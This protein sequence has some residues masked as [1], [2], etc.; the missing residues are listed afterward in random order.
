MLGKLEWAARLGALAVAFSLTAISGAAAIYGGQDA[1]P[2]AFPFM[3]SLEMELPHGIA[4]CGGT[5]ISDQWVLT[6]AHC[7]IDEGA[8]RVFVYAGSDNQ[9]QG[10]KIQADQWK[11]HPNYDVTYHNNDLALIHLPRPPQLTP[12]FKVKWS[13]NPNRFPDPVALSDTF[14]ASFHRDVTVV[15]WG[16]TAPTRPIAGTIA[17]GGAGA[18][19]IIAGTAPTL[20]ML[21]FRVASSQYC[22]ARWLS[23]T[24]AGLA[25]QLD[26]L[27][28][29]DHA[30]SDLLDMARGAGPRAFPTGA[31]CGSSS[32]DAFG[33]PVGSGLLFQTLPGGG[34]CVGLGC[35]GPELCIGPG[36]QLS[37]PDRKRTLRLP[38]RQRR[39]SSCQGGGRELDRGRARQLWGGGGGGGSVQL[40][41]RAFR[42]HQCRILR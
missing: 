10:D 18:P 26:G 22:N 23:S 3:V 42:L 28:L 17:G 21:D 40:D 16:L 36:L 29:S 25:E 5:L 37:H 32:V 13:T 27:G 24:M 20:Q 1:P 39:S 9:W 41:H 8:V 38:R 30:I 31:F 4:L 15:G 7:L 2:R 12:V 34:L 6:A 35:R 33:N 11:V 19:Q 14:I